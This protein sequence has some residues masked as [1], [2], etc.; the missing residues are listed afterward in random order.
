MVFRWN[1]ENLPLSFLF[2][3][4]IC[5]AILV[6]SIWWQP[7][8][9][10][11]TGRYIESNMK[12]V[13]IWSS[14][15]IMWTRVRVRADVVMWFT[16]RLKQLVRCSD[17]ISTNS[18][19]HRDTKGCKVESLYCVHFEIFYTPCTFVTLHYSVIWLSNDAVIFL[20]QI[21]LLFSSFPFT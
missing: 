12:C 3:S 5:T 15:D 6:M 8:P 13:W 14:C 21:F 16:G 20:Y 11:K 9:N 2:I 10:I 17:Q 7:Y 19:F 4:H 18:H 1:W